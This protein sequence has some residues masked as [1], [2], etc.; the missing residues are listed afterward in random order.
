MRFGYEP[1]VEVLV[2][3]DRILQNLR[4]FRE[5][6][7]VPVAP[8]LKS[9]AYGHGL[10][11]VAKI[12]EHEAIPFLCV[13]SYYEAL[14]LRNENV[15]VPL[16]VLGYTPLPNIQKSKLPDVA[17]SVASMPELV[18]LS[19]KL[20]SPRSFHLEI[21]TGMHRHGIPLEDLGGAVTLIKN[22]RNI[23]LEGAFSHLADADN[24]NSSLTP[25]QISRWN[26]AAAMIKTE[27]PQAYRLHLA[28]TAGS[29]FSERIDADIIRLGLGLYG[30][31]GKKEDRL[32]IAP[33]L[34]MRSR[35]A[36]LRTVGPGEKVGYRATFEAKEK[37]VLATVP[38]GYFEG[39][40]LRLSNKGT[41]TVKGIPCPITG[42]V[43]MN[44]TSIDVSRVENPEL[45]MPVTVISPARGGGNSVEEIAELC[46]TIP[47]EIL[48]HIPAHL[49]RTVL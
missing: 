6:Y 12:V 28:A 2:Y 33:A 25:E 13:D 16:L 47:Y 43:S 20:S 4:A 45:D 31:G 10:V 11:E 14:V 26:G 39:V 34:E 15:H 1:L 24:P 19:E 5:R 42:R 30:I 37:T 49:R 22:N 18:R 27:F 23:R 29:Q 17:F 8:V 40:D 35:I 41:M 36:S 7:Q 44:I 48:V 38:V 3:K 21:D 46:G 9:N 32:E